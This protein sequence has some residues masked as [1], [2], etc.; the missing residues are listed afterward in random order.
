M[1]Y[2]SSAASQLGFFI[3]LHLF[4]IAIIV[5]VYKLSTTLDDARNPTFIYK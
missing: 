5:S 3:P 1:F 4:P 2:C